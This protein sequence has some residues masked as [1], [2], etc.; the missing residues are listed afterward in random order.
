MVEQPIEVDVQIAGR[1]VPAG[2]LWTH[3]HGQSESATFSYREE[4]LQRADAYELDPGLPLQAASSK[5]RSNILCSER[6]PTAPRA[7]GDGGSSDARRQSGPAR[8]IPSNAGSQRS[9]SCSNAAE[10]LERD[11]PTSED[12][13][14]QE[15]P[16]GHDLTEHTAD[17]SGLS[18]PLQSFYPLRIF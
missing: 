11:E 4:Y 15:V 14:S 16:P 2:R 9:T 3:R 6:C 18:T 1:A 10:E 13:Q 5:R 12:R 17:P 8:P 7:A